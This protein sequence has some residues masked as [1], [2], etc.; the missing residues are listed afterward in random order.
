MSETDF[1]QRALNDLA[2]IWSN[3]HI[4]HLATFDV[5]HN[6]LGRRLNLLKGDINGQWARWFA[7]SLADPRRF[8]N[9]NISYPFLY[10]EVRSAINHRFSISKTLN[11]KNKMASVAARIIE[12][13]SQS[14]NATHRRRITTID[15]KRLLLDISGSDPRCWICGVSFREK[16]IEN[17]V[18]GSKYK[19]GLPPFIDVLKPRGLVERDFAIEI[20]HVVP[21]SRGGKGQDNLKLACGWCNRTKSANMSIY[22]VEGQP[23]LA[24]PNSLGLT[25]LPQPFWIVRLLALVRTCE[26]PDGCDRSVENTEM[27]VAPI[28]EGGA[29]NPANLRVTCYK[30]DPIKNKR[31]QPPSKIKKIWCY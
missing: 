23:R 5:P 22:E 8:V 2:A 9:S 14:I 30:H 3:T 17:F 26:H 13:L 25:S 18:S 31:L 29:L 11:E 4:N 1:I 20:D 24:G 7:E 21:F 27:T 6:I 15:E 19:I 10:N 16:A 28:W 12:N